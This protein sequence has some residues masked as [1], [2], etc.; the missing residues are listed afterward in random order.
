MILTTSNLT[1]SIDVAFLDRTDIVYYIGQ[2]S[3]G[4]I[5]KIFLGAIKE[6][7]RA[8]I[9][10][11]FD[12]VVL[13]NIEAGLGENSQ[14]LQELSTLA[15]GISGRKLRKLPLIAHSLFLKKEQASLPEFFCAME[16]AIRKHFEDKPTIKHHNKIELEA[17]H[18]NG[19]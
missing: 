18:V 6:L 1:S 19:Y 14:K 7:V 16:K 15:V 4:S 13:K 9:I 2:P 5:Y 17:G 11:V 10:D 8:T 12:P 3:Q